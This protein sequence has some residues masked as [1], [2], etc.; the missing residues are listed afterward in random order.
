MPV[1]HSPSDLTRQWTTADLPMRPE[2][3]PV[4]MEHLVGERRPDLSEPLEVRRLVD[5]REARIAEMMR[6]LS[7]ERVLGRLAHCFDHVAH[8]VRGY[9]QTSQQTKLALLTGNHHLMIGPTGSGK[10]FYARTVMG[11][12]GTEISKFAD[13]LTYEKDE[14]AIYGLIPLR[15]VEDGTGCRNLDG[16]LALAD[17]VLLDEVFDARDELLRSL[18]WPISDRV[19][20]NGNAVVPATVHS[21]L[22]CGNYTRCNDKTAAFLDRFLF[23]TEVARVRSPVA[24]LSI[25]S[26]YA[27]NRDAPQLPLEERLSV[28]ELRYISAVIDGKIPSERVRVAP[29]ILMLLDAVVTDYD[30]RRKAILEAEGKVSDSDV[31][32]RNLKQLARVV[33]AHALL[34]GRRAATWDDLASLAFAVPVAGSEASS[35]IFNESWK[36]VMRQGAS[37]PERNVLRTL[38]SLTEMLK[39]V[40][41]GA[42]LRPM[43]LPEQIL[44]YFGWTTQT[45]IS[46]AELKQAIGKLNPGLEYARAYQADLILEVD[47]AMKRRGKQSDDPVGATKLG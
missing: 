43:T 4:G 11:I 39:Q 15:K 37:A 19:Y 29:E 17:V 27:T 28:A 24:R 14:G 21:V 46:Y 13:Q 31:S 32:E 5:E 25:L 20:R 3:S 33:V 23:Q 26:D 7:P 30:S 42:V 6:E 35:G 22:A 10:S 45:A 9:E 12:F 8:Y 18:L 1:I 36:Q 40:E 47:E 2:G 16:S 41:G 44:T 34:H 38:S